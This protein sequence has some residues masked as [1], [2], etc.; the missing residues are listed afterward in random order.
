MVVVFDV[1]SLVHLGVVM[2]YLGIFLHYK[3]Y[4][5]Y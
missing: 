2:T 5:W 1:M 4:G 3:N